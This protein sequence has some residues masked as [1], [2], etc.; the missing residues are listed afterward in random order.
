MTTSNSQPPFYQGQRVVCVDD[1]TPSGFVFI[2]NS[3]L[4][5]KKEKVYPVKGVKQFSCGCWAIDIGAP[6]CT[7]PHGYSL[8]SNCNKQYWDEDEIQWYRHNRFA[9]IEPLYADIRES[10]AKEAMNVHDTAD[11]P[12]KELINSN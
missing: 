12:I 1:S 11:Q 2:H 10:L 6:L 9:P 7:L 4:F 3:A 5:L 8:C